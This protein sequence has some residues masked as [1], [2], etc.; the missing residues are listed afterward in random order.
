MTKT[1]SDPFS[2][3]AAAYVIAAASV[4]ALAFAFVM[5]FGFGIEPCE[6]CLWQRAPFAATAVV[7]LIAAF[8][9]PFERYM[10]LLLGLCA[11]LFL[12]STGLAVFHSGVERHWW[13]WH[14]GCTALNIDAD[15]VEE[16]LQKLQHT[17]VA[18]CD[19]IGWAF[20]GLSMANWNIPFS[21]ALTLFSAVAARKAR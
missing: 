16:I 2:S 17:P 13:V 5:Q 9:R 14:S 19:Q 18:R 4:G 1:P 7:A 21:L 11:A 3:P 15:S 6:L 8:V 20:L 10:W 12:A